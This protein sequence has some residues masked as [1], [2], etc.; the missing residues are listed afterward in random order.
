[1][2]E[3]V[4]LGRTYTIG[5]AAPAAGIPTQRIRFVDYLRNVLPNEWVASWS[6]AALDAGAIA[7]K[8]FAWYTAVIERKWRSQGYPF[9]LVDNTCDQYYRD[10]S[11]DPRTD[12]AIQRT[13]GTLLTRHG[14]LLRTYYRDTEAGCGGL[15]DCM[16]QVESAVLASAGQSTL[17][18][19]ARYYNAPG[20]AVR[21]T[22]ARLPAQLPPVP[23]APPIPLQPAATAPPS[24]TVT[25]M[26]ALT[27]TLLAPTQTI[28]ATAGTVPPTE[29][30]TQ[31]PTPTT[32]ASTT[33]PD[34]P[35]PE[36][37]TPAQLTPATA[38]PPTP[39]RLTPATPTAAPLPMTPILPTARPV[40]VLPSLVGLGENQ[41]R[42]LLAGLGIT[43]V[44]ADYQ[45]RDRLGGLYDQFPAYAV[46]SHSPPAGAP[47]TP[48][49]QVVL[50]IRAP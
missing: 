14:V 20:T 7:A 16:G 15:P 28:T 36:P 2:P 19:L 4:V 40:A 6:P 32:S 44:I 10:A 9:D 37:P 31:A 50:G 5:C 49:A 39:A 38:E 22:G 18:I 47:A 12:A 3:Y 33:A 11:A 30:V 43:N 46:V 42:E 25:P 24:P 17:Q 48:D 23:P 35:A 13:W 34:A 21:V 1:M 41:A 26:P 29:T 8:Q 27:P 45:G